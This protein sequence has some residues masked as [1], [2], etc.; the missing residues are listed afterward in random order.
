MCLN[1]QVE[2]VVLREIQKHSIKCRL[3]KFEI[4]QAVKLVSEVWTPDTGLVTD[5]FKLKRKQIQEH[6]QPFIDRMYS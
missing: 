3:E 2:K 1:R 5:A 4:P 6:Y